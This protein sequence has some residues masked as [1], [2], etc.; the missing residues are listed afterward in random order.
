MV[1]HWIPSD[2]SSPLSCDIPRYVSDSFLSQE[3]LA[4]FKYSAQSGITPGTLP[5]SLRSL[6]HVLSGDAPM[7]LRS[8]SYYRIPRQLPHTPHTCPTS[9]QLAAR[10]VPVSI[11]YFGRF[12]SDGPVGGF[13]IQGQQVVNH[14][15]VM[16]ALNVVPFV[17]FVPF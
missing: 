15:Q 2:V 7:F 17:P 14:L 8:L 11:Q 9:P 10:Q 13:P 6:I 3:P 4:S 5:R 12:P 1:L 16:Q